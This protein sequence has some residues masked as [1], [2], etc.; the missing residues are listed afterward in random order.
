MKKVLMMAAVCL[1]TAMTFAA[2]CAATTKKGTQCK[3][4][5]SPGS[6]YCWQH[7]GTTKAQR[8]ANGESEAPKRSRKAAQAEPEAPAANDAPAAVEGQC[9]ATTKRGTQ[10][11]RKAVEGG[12]YCAQHAGKMSGGESAEPAARPKRTRSAKVES[13]A[14]AAN[15]APAVAEGQCQA[16]TKSGAPCKRKAQAGGKYCAQH[17]VILGGAE[18]EAP[19]AKPAKKSAEADTAVPAATGL[20]QGKTKSGEPCKRKAKPGSK[21]CWQHDK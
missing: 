19:A 1:M 4:P 18:A 5:A 11:R 3:R 7:G 10:C 9:Q 2:Q 14:P 15:D 8:A 12:K 20:C 17:A 16:T 13:E 6:E 21:F